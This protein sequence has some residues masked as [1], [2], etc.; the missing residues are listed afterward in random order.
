MRSLFTITGVCA[1][2]ALGAAGC[3]GDDNNDSSSSAGS[4]G[5]EQSGGGGGGAY[6]PP[7]SSTETKASGGASS[8]GNTITVKMQNIQFDPKS[9]NAKV[10]QT[11]KWVNDDTV[12]HNVTATKGEEFKSKDFGEGGTYSYK[13]DKPGTIQY[14]CTLHPGMEATIT[15]TK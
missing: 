8:S 3:G 13:L 14:V 1:V 2:L 11:I 10:G 7:A 9:L 4:T 6:A 12:D 5:T 15:V